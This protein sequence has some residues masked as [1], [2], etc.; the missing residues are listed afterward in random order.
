[1]AVHRARLRAGGTTYVLNEL[2][3][4][5]DGDAMGVR[6]LR[7]KVIRRLARVFP[8]RFRFDEVMYSWIEAE[9]RYEP[10]DYHGSAD[11]FSVEWTLMRGRADL[12]PSEDKGWSELVKG[13]LAVHRVPGDHDSMLLEPNV[14]V[15][16]RRVEAVI[17]ER[18]QQ[19]DKKLRA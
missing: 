17:E 11:L 18:L 2:K 19:L 15:L 10:K 4:T 3:N 6:Q 7:E 5:L 16:A 1:M 14:G 13:D 9:R 8:Y 12:V